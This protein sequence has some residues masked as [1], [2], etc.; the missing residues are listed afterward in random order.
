LSGLVGLDLEAEQ[1]LFP[2]AEA[3][4]GCCVEARIR[5]HEGRLGIKTGVTAS[6]IIVAPHL[7]ERAVRP[8]PDAKIPAWTSALV[9]VTLPRVAPAAVTVLAKLKPWLESP[10]HAKLGQHLKYDQHV[11]ANHGIRLAGIAHDTLL[12]SY[13]FESD[14]GHHLLGIP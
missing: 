3:G 7:V 11:F 5:G 2:V 14:K 10:Q 9:A 4:Q 6:G 1:T 8:L 13:V 12:E